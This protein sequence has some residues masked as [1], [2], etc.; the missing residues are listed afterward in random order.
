MYVCRWSFVHN[1]SIVRGRVSHM[2][3]CFDVLHVCACTCTCFWI[4]C[5]CAHVHAHIFGFP[6]RVRMYMHI[7]LDFL[8]VCACTCTCLKMHT[9]TRALTHSDL[10]YGWVSIAMR[11]LPTA[12]E[13]YA[14]MYV[15]MYVCMYVCIYTCM[16]MHVYTLFRSICL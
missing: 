6:A 14:C 12:L 3:G 9:R 10:I 11:S 2:H 7:F 8:H 16:R 15:Y 4:S 13:M 1:N 5:T